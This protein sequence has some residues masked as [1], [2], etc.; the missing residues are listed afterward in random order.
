MA[1]L[2]DGQSCLIVPSLS[3]LYI[4]HHQCESVIMPQAPFPAKDIINPCQDFFFYATADLQN[5][6]LI[7]FI[8]NFTFYHSAHLLRSSF[9]AFS[10]QEMSILFET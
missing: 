9:F 8:A 3:G 4:C 1:W 7:I 5:R 10:G 2:E 6:L